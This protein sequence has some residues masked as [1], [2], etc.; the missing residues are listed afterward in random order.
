MRY[1]HLFLGL[2]TANAASLLFFYGC[3]LKSGGDGSDAG[4]TPDSSIDTGVD[5]G[6]GGECEGVDLQ[7]DRENCG[8]CKRSCLGSACNAGQCVPTRF[9]AIANAGEFA[10]DD[11][12]AVVVQVPPPNGSDGDVYY[13]SFSADGGTIR[14]VVGAEL[15]LGPSTD[16]TS[17]CWGNGGRVTC[18]SLDGGN[19]RSSA[20]GENGPKS[21]LILGD[22][23]YWI[24]NGP[25]DIKKFPLAGGAKTVVASGG[26]ITGSH[27]LVVD[28][29]RLVWVVAPTKA[30]VTAPVDGDGGSP[31]VLGTIPAG[32]PNAVAV[33][34]DHYYIAAQNASASELGGIYRV[35]KNATGGPAELVMRQSLVDPSIVVVSDFVYYTNKVDEGAVYRFKVGDTPPD[36]GP[37]AFVSAQPSP[38][39]VRAGADGFIYWTN[40][41]ADGGL[42]RVA[43]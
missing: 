21:T 11:A 5:S 33:G 9:A 14:L 37:P 32:T 39:A 22:T 8:V 36:G 43:K 4:P 23:V 1:R 35:A 27:S 42:M 3:D 31:I 28:G 40:S 12:G 15:P 24:N 25:G 13:A 7:T 6:P 19:S 20:T 29:T 38:K 17:A 10:V 16:G 30:V 34:T 18:S 2:L 41:V 26:G